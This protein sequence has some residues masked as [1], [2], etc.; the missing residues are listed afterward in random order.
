VH[1][2]LGSISSMFYKQ[3]WSSQILKVQKKPDNL[4]LFFELMGSVRLTAARRMLL[5]L[6]PGVNFTSFKGSFFFAQIPKV[7]K[8]IDYLTV[9]M[10]FWDLGS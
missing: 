5:K 3:L 7:Q 9:F 10:R 4:T 6:N 1:G 8:Y 2:D